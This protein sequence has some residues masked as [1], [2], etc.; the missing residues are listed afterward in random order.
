M[1]AGHALGP[2]MAVQPLASPGGIGVIGRY[3]EQTQG[4][5]VQRRP[6]HGGLAFDMEPPAA[7]GILG[8]AQMEQH[9]FD[10]P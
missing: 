4:H 7:I 10:L 3:S 8:V 6:E 9:A 5:V 2:A 1:V